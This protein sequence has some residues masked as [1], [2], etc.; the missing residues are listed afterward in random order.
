MAANY[1]D[2]FPADYVRITDGVLIRNGVVLATTS[3]ADPADLYRALG[4]SYPKFFKMDTLC[5][6]AWLGAEA[7]LRNGESSLYDDLDK[8]NIAVVLATGDGCLEIDHKYA[9]SMQTIS[10][11]ALFVYTLPNI[12]LGE[13]CIRHGFTG[14]QLCEL[15]EAFNPEAVLDW[16]SDLIGHRGMSHC[17]FGWVN[18]SGDNYDVSLFWTGAEALQKLSRHQLQIIHNNSLP[19]QL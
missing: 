3:G 16:V 9:E 12:M 1:P 8:R 6:W 14:E 11:P 19:T 7:L 15:Q 4:C 2:P 5:K 13:I 10:S 17:L 18:A